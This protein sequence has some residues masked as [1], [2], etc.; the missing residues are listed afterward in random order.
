[1]WTIFKVFKNL[2]RC[3]FCFIFWCFGSEVC[4]ILAP[5]LGF[6]PVPPPPTPTALEG[7]VLTS[8]PPG[9]SQAVVLKIL[10]FCKT[11]PLRESQPLHLVPK[12]AKNCF[13]WTWSDAMVSSRGFGGRLWSSL[14]LSP[15][16]GSWGLK[17]PLCVAEVIQDRFVLASWVLLP[18]VCIFLFLFFFYFFSKNVFNCVKNCCLWWSNNGAEK[19]NKSSS[20]FCLG[21]T[22]LE[23][24]CMLPCLC[25]ENQAITLE[26]KISFVQCLQFRR[27][28]QSK[29]KL[30]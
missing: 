12:Q 30:Y 5:Q 17:L 16:A 24:L 13:C 7:K 4:Q 11:W 22:S 14:E 29:G 9:K 20:F 18:L 25:F 8:G 15:N 28:I 26:V 21:M 3:R 1:M 10:V 19:Q 2:L 23:L 6:K 27:E